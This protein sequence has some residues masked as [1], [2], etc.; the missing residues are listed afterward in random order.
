VLDIRV[1]SIQLGLFTCEAYSSLSD[2]L[3]IFVHVASILSAL[4]I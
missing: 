2:S 3:A 1:A 4:S